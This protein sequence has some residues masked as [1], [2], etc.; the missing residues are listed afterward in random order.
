MSTRWNKLHFNQQRERMSKNNYVKDH[1]CRVCGK[2]FQSN[3]SKICPSCAS[4]V[5]DELKK[6]KEPGVS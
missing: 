2:G 5:R 4:F 6:E 3:G 1:S